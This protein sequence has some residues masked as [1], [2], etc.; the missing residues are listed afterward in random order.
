MD[1]ERFPEVIAIMASIIHA[2]EVA[3]PEYW[4]ANRQGEVVEPSARAAVERALEI[5]GS[6]KCLVE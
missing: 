1:R 5:W 6:V 3:R 4:L 2:A